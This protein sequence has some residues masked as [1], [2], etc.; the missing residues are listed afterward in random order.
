MHPKAGHRIGDHHR[1]VSRAAAAVSTSS[2]AA[3]LIA[4]KDGLT[5]E[6]FFGDFRRHET[7]AWRG[8][9]WHGRPNWW[10]AGSRGARPGGLWRLRIPT[11]PTTRGRVA[12]PGSAS[13]AWPAPRLP[14]GRRA[15]RRETR[16]RS[17][18]GRPRPTSPKKAGASESKERHLLLNFRR[19]GGN[20]GKSGVPLVAGSSLL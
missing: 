10:R 5:E 12:Q 17:G 11:G 7:P 13:A 4:Y 9:P 1:R 15:D 3:P 2:T 6:D 20:E 16:P 14:P 19:S 8:R 18:Q